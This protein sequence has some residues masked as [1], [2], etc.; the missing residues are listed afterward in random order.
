VAPAASATPQGAIVGE[1]PLSDGGGFWVAYSGGAVQAVGTAVWYGDSAGSPLNQPIV[2]IAST[3]DGGGYWLV[4]ADGGIFSYGDAHFYGSAGS[5]HLNAPIVAVAS[6]PDGGGYWLVAA[7]GGI[8]SYGDAHFYGS[9]GSIH[10][11]APIVAVASTP[12]GGGYWLV[13][14]DGGIFSYGDAHYLGSTASMRLNQ[15][16]IGMA[17][18]ADG[19]GYWLV[20]KDGGVFAFGDAPF[21]G[22]ATANLDSARA[23]GMVRAPHNG[24]WILTSSGAV[25]PYAA[26]A[27]PAPDATTTPTAGPVK[28]LPAT[29]NPSISIAPSSA[30]EIACFAGT[31]TAACDR[32][33]LADINQ[34][35]SGEGLGSLALPADFSTLNNATQ[36]IV[37]ANAERTSRGLPALPEDATLDALAQTGAQ[38]GQDPT[39]P[40]GYTWRSNIAWGYLTPLAA[41]FGWMYD[42]GPGSSNLACTATVTSGC[43][44]HRENILGAGVGSAGAGVYADNGVSQLTQLFVDQYQVVGMA[45]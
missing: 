44:G 26:P 42:D 10:L 23:V 7:D 21:R 28:V 19:Q 34:A 5:I 24:Y 11:N 35:R 12:D 3:P 18:S 41:D 16:V 29:W 43:W 40:D 33:A 31:N 25:I 4:A 36:S 30:F 20:A 8:F 37:V 32:A 13:A 39:G 17:A 15:P 45:G 2:G 1:A 6:T 14:A 9:A 22:T 27:M 38:S